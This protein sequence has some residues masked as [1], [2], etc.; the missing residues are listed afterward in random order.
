MTPSITLLLHHYLLLSFYEKNTFKNTDT[1][2][3][4]HFRIIIEWIQGKYQ[5][6]MEVTD[7]DDCTFVSKAS[8][9]SFDN[10]CLTRFFM[11]NVNILQDNLINVAM[12]WKM[13]YLSSCST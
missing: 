13:N 1:L 9:S 11:L 2:F 12:I 4:G 10:E 3:N 6:K 8:L 5:C 7:V